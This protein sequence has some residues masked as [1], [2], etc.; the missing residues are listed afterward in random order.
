MHRYANDT[1]GHGMV[2]DNTFRSVARIEAPFLENGMNMHELLLLP[3]PQGASAIH[4]TAQSNL[5]DL[6]GIGTI[7]QERG[8]AIDTGFRE[9]NI[10]TGETIFDWWPRDHI[11]LTQS[12]VPIDDNAFKRPPSGWNWL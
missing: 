2:L 5:E 1:T 3:S 9:V 6:R 4:L 10:E 11:P 7:G 12:T 8:W